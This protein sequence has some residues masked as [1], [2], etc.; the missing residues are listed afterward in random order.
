MK[1]SKVSTIMK[2]PTTRDFDRLFKVSFF[3]VIDSGVNSGTAKERMK[4][5]YLPNQLSKPSNPTFLRLSIK[6]MA[7]K[8][9]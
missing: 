3:A 8:E 2:R 4:D 5:I 9:H 6:S 7:N 1:T